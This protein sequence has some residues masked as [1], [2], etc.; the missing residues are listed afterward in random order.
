EPPVI[1]DFAE[2][3]RGADKI[4]YSRTLEAVSSARTRLERSF[5]AKE[6]RRLKGSAD[7]DVSIGGPTIAG[8]ALRAGLVDRIG[9]F[10]FPVTVGGGLRALPAD[11][12][13]SLEL[14]DERRFGNG[15][16]YL[17]YRVGRGPRT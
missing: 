8:E 7:G 4:V 16:M 3:W 2:I 5:D 6:V 9:L 12:R 11:L 10:L 13:L 14:F 15:V 17:G 1:R